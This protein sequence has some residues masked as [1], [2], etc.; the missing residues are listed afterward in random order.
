MQILNKTLKFGIQRA[1]AATV[2]QL[3][4]HQ[5]RLKRRKKNQRRKRN[6]RRKRVHRLKEPL[7][8]T[9]KKRIQNQAEKKRKKMPAKLNPFHSRYYYRTSWKILSFILWFH[10]PQIHYFCSIKLPLHCA[11]ISKLNQNAQHTFGVNCTERFLCGVNC[12]NELL[13][14]NKKEG[15]PRKQRDVVRERMQSL[16]IQVRPVVR[17]LTDCHNKYYQLTN[18]V[19]LIDRVLKRVK[20]VTISFFNTLAHFQ[21][22]CMD[23]LLK[24]KCVKFLY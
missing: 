5:N 3:Q 13:I 20:S 21:Q 9:Q 12:M 10:W 22:T 8:L 14:D 4:N 19:N 15:L 1:L 11:L 6:R 18:T 2:V 23:F 24:K 7:R 17:W 16:T